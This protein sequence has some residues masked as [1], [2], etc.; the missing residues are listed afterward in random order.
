MLSIILVNY[1]NT[2]D[3]IRCLN[4]LK[5]QNYDDYEIIIVE[6]CSNDDNKNLLSN[7]LTSIKKEVKF[8][9]KIK[10]IF[11]NQNL[12]Y[13]GGNNLGIR[14]SKGDIILLL[15][16]DTV[17]S[18]SFLKTMNNFFEQYEFIHIAQPLIYYF[19]EKN[20]IWCNGYKFYKY[21]LFLNKN[22]NFIDRA[23][24]NKPYRIDIADGCAF[25]I[26]REV[27]KEIGLFENIFHIYGEMA[28]MCYRAR[29][30][31]Y[32]NIYCNPLTEI[33][34]DTLP[35]F[36]DL[37]K[38]YFF[39]NRMIFFLKHFS[40]SLILAQSFLHFVRLFLVAIDLNNKK[41][42]YKFFFISIIRMI[43]GFIL[44]LKRRLN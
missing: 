39:R 43:N 30:N 11:S 13:G 9:N 14:K 10:I 21:S 17:H 24:I 25:F 28:D 16:S 3:T 19:K 12:G 26:K 22:L 37:Q 7:F 20:K 4:S 31:G 5:Y 35:G 8:F 6:N 23:V 1:N 15:N 27:L 32:N 29:L 38:R 41:F 33:Y 34:H 40:L 36:S 42:D 44:G 2:N 18:V